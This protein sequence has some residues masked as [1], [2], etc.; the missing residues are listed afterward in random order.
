MDSDEMSFSEEESEDEEQANTPVRDYGENREEKKRRKKE[1][2]KKKTEEVS[3]CSRSASYTNTTAT[4]LILLRS[5]QK[6]KKLEHEIV[7]RSS[8][9]TALSIPA[10]KQQQL[11]AAAQSKLNTSEAPP[12]SQGKSPAASDRKVPYK[13]KFMDL[14]D[15][16]D[17]VNMHSKRGESFRKGSG[18]PPSLKKF[19]HRDQ[20]L[21]DLLSEENMNRGVPMRKEYEVQMDNTGGE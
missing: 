12:P 17:M 8:S 7:R 13:S 11:L 5:S 14:A 6:E 16:V 2:K 15:D 10:E 4:Q 1:E 21:R 20:S 3:G 19:A 9:I 18:G